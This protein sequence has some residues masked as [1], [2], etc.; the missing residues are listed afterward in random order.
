MWGRTLSVFA[1][2]AAV[3]CG[4]SPTSPSG[5]VEAVTWTVNGESFRATSNGMSALRAAGNLSLVAADCG[6]GPNLG[7]LVTAPN[8]G[9]PGAYPVGNGGGFSNVTWTPDAR[10]GASASE[11]WS[12]PGLPRVVNGVLVGGGSGS[13]AISSIS[14]DWVSG[15]FTFEVI[16]NPGNRDPANKTIQGTFELS[17]RERTIC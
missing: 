7:M 14:N 3:A 4:G 6:R 5:A 10:S 11:A 8:M 17:F 9:G 16:A 1:A 13:I 15:S 2:V 12:A